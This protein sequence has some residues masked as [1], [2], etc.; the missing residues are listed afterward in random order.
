ME[1]P[2]T[3]AQRMARAASIGILS[4]IY[5]EAWDMLQKGDAFPLETRVPWGRGEET[6]GVILHH[7]QQSPITLLRSKIYS[8]VQLYK[9]TK[10]SVFYEMLDGFFW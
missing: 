5:T 6:E 8:N 7:S 4:R 2:E 10:A 9:I 1:E 3:M